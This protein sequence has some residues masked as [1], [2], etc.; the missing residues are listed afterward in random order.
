MPPH[1]HTQL[2]CKVTAQASAAS[3]PLTDIRVSS[4]HVCV[5]MHQQPSTRPSRQ[6]AAPAGLQLRMGTPHQLHPFSMSGACC[7]RC[8][9]QL[10]L[11]L[12]FAGVHCCCRSQLILLLP[13]A[14]MHCRCRSQLALLL[15]AT[16]PTDQ[17]L[18]AAAAM[19][20][21]VRVLPVWLLL[22]QPLGRHDTGAAAAVLP[23]TGSCRCSDCSCC[24]PGEGRRG[25]VPGPPS[26]SS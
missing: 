9:S 19:S 8:R 12:P 14:G 21:D 6:P 3:T 11:L 23:A 16:A 2:P 24:W 22:L 20:T 1:T 7:F 17:L 5:F 10:A 15:K 25:C 4:A 18:S 26:S 13:F